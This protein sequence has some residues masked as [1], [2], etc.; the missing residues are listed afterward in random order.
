MRASPILLLLF[1]LA[2]SSA[3]ADDPAQTD[4]SGGPGTVGP[5]SDWGNVFDSAD[6]VSWLALPG[7]IA[8]RSVRR[9]PVETLITDAYMGSFGVHAAD[10]DGDGD[11]DVIGAADFSGLVLVWLNQ[12]TDPPTWT[13]QTVDDDFAHCQDVWPAD[14][15]GD[16]DVDIVGNATGTL[17]RIVY[18][19]NDGGNPVVW[20]RRLIE[21]YWST[22]YEVCV[23]DVDRDGRLDVISGSMNDAEVAWW[24][25]EGGTP[26][27]WTKQCVDSLL[28]GVHSVRVADFDGDGDEDLA[29]AAAEADQIVW[30]RNDGGSPFQWS[31]FVIR[32]NYEGARSVCPGDFDND[33]DQDLIG[34]C[35]QQTLSLW[36]NDGGDPIV[37]TEEIIDSI[38]QGGH[39]VDAADMNG[40]GLLDVVSAAFVLNDIK[41]WENGGGDP[42]QWTKWHVDRNLGG[43]VK[44]HAADLDGDGSMEILGSAWN[45]GVF[46]WYEV[47]DFVTSGELDGS[48]LDTGGD[49]AVTGV[50][51]TADAPAGT[52]LRFR[53]R[54]SADPLDLGDWSAE[55]TAPG[56]LPSPAARYFQYKVIME[57]VDPDH[58]PI[59]RDLLFSMDAT[60]VGSG[61]PPAA[62]LF[63]E[64][65]PN[66]FNPSTTLV[67]FLSREER[68]RL[69][70][71][72]PMGRVVS[73]LKDRVL[74]AGEHAFSWNGKDARG[75]PVPSGVYLA[76]LETEGRDESKKLV[77]I[78]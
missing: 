54:S 58:S 19:E 63:L 2:F 42:I 21:P 32:E 22:A 46:V 41:W 4:W 26:L 20:T 18:W 39:H 24:R 5:V 13:E 9:V 59:L 15:D 36:R 53:V 62:D 75:R 6:S 70:V 65:R 8:L 10:V 12:G 51:W 61:A 7:Q 1:V 11:M 71:Y 30:Y 57:T 28:A 29:A 48:V 69:R 72:D 16:G 64:A 67:F 66:P 60:A 25:N 3:S 33:G 40:D 44:A 55:I 78:R 50:D 76:R 38:W 17:N 37:W 43:A 73:V 23:H 45:T 34:T 31:K 14:L 77:L 35:W 68:A 27:S 47:S 49:G 56:D 74:P 52:S